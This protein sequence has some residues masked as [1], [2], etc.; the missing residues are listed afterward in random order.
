MKSAQN[1]PIARA[2]PLELEWSLTRCSK[3]ATDI[4][5]STEARF[6]KVQSVVLDNGDKVSIG[7]DTI[8]TGVDGKVRSVK[9]Y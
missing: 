5:P 9:S 4:E 3:F 1:A 2:P 7:D 6:M 8:A